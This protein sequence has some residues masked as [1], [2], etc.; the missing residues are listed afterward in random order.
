M[1]TI[2][3][4][5]DLIPYN[6]GV[7][8]KYILQNVQGRELTDICHTHDF[9]EIVYVLRG[10]CRQHINDS[11]YEQGRGE[12][13]IIRP[14]ESHYFCAQSK[15]MHL[16]SI[17]AKECEFRSAADIYGE[18]IY[19]QIM[20]Q[21]GAVL[22]MGSGVP[23][24]LLLL[25]NELLTS[26]EEYVYKHFLTFLIKLYIDCRKVKEQIPSRISALLLEMQRPENLRQGVSR[27]VELSNYSQSQLKRHIKKYC[28]CSLQQY[29]FNTRMTFAFNDIVLTCEKIEDIAEKYGYSSFS[30][31]NQS[32]KRRFNITPAALKKH[33][34]YWTI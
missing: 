13:C 25:F 29:I 30:H 23:A 27:F 2:E 21:K 6:A 14:G 20:S 32:F 5:F 7:K 31:F 22:M 18:N 26:R 12:W 11:V 19:A 33:H 24:D 17:A 4:K 1:K 34:R 8:G 15:D 10:S 3:Y 16:F 9:F 28:G